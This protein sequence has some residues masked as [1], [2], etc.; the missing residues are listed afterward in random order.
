MTFEENLARLEE[1]VAELEAEGLD[2]D[3]ALK[4]FEEG[5][6]RLRDASASLSSAESR[7]REL[8]EEAEGTFSVED[9]ER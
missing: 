9:R 4:L 2:L 6:E 5:V 7:V 3:R 1:I 8:V